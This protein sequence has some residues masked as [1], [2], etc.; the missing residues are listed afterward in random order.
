MTATADIEF[1]DDK[2]VIARMDGYEC[3]INADLEK[4]FRSALAAA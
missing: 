3:T 2:G 4:A 1:S